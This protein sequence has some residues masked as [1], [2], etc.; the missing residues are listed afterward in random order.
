MYCFIV[1]GHRDFLVGNTLTYEHDDD[2]SKWTE[3]PD[4]SV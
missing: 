2:V 1:L 3:V 4:N